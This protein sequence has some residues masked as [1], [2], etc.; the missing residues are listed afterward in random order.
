MHCIYNLHSVKSGVLSNEVYFNDKFGIMKCMN[1]YWNLSLILSLL[2]HTAIFVRVPYH[3]RQK[4]QLVKNKS[5]K[6]IT[7]A[8]EKIETI[9][10]RK[11]NTFEGVEP[12]PYIENLMNKLIKP[13]YIS[14][15]EKQKVFTTDL[16]ETIF[17]NFAKSSY[18][19]KSP[20]YMDYYRLVR[21]KIRTN[22]YQNYNTRKKGEVTI[23]FLVLKNGTLRAVKLDPKSVRSKRLRNIA[24]K[25]IKQSAPFPDFPRELKKYSHLKFNIS[26]H[27]KN[28]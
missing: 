26:I 10:K 27:F 5:R 19:K 4:D 22:A 9:S 1:N 24:L 20:A 17:S 16:S 25:S 13:R 6:E 21:E 15:V 3:F 18:L 28:N 8:P 7:M 12:L 14:P 2:V 11:F 23:T